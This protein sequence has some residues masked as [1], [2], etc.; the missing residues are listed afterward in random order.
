[1]KMPVSVIPRMVPR[2][3]RLV[4][5]P[6]IVARLPSEICPGNVSRYSGSAPAARMNRKPPAPRAAS[7]A[8]S[9]CIDRKLPQESV[10][11]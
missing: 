8:F 1:M 2:K 7:T 3:N 9:I 10:V 6:R 5:R 11:G 4:R